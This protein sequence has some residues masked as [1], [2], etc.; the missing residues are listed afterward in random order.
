MTI[1]RPLGLALA[2][3]LAA[4]AVSP[5]AEARPRARR[6]KKF[7]A[8]K[9]FGLGLMLG[10]P[11]AIA[12]KYYYASDKAFDFGVGAMR[13]YR[14][15]DGLHLHVDHL[16]HPVS[17]VSTASFELPLYLGLGL[18]IFDFDDNANDD[19]VAIGVRAPIGIAFDFNT[20]PIDIFIELALVADFFVDYGDRYD[21]DVNGAVGF[22]YYFE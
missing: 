20:A 17:L 5:D 13:Y 14:H 19:G 3:A 10:A 7:E 15:R 22:R 4:T 6:A 1:A 2:V 8:N 9:T 12:G 21:G 18:R 11:T 16:W